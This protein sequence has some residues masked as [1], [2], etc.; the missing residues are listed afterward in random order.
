MARSSS[1]AATAS[2]SA[3]LSAGNCP[4]KR[5][6]RPNACLAAFTMSFAAGAS[7]PRSPF[8]ARPVTARLSTGFHALTTTSSHMSEE[9]NR[10]LKRLRFS[11]Q[12][13]WYGLARPA[14]L[15]LK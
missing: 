9:A 7:V 1:D 2:A 14:G 11:P 6:T 10:T 13:T 15:C 4:A 12:R 8:V 5:V 3:W